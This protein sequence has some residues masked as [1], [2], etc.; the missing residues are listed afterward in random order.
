[1]LT[2]I[3]SLA[4]LFIAAAAFAFGGKIGYVIGAVATLVSASATV[5]QYLESKP[6]ILFVKNE[7]WVKN[8]RNDFELKI[9][10]NLHRKGAHPTVVTFLQDVEGN[11]EEAI[12][13]CQIS[14]LGDITL[15]AGKTWNGKAVIK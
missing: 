1:M 9:S 11:M 13:D 2:L 4:G 6:F 14:E 3:L 10:R 12:G 15:G 5:R 7:T 8:D